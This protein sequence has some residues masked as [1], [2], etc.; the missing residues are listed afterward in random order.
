V[1]D[2]HPEYVDELF[3]QVRRHPKTLTQLLRI[4]AEHLHEEDLAKL[5]AVQLAAAPN[6]LKTTLIASLDVMQD[7]PAAMNAAAAA[8]EARPRETARMLVQRELAVKNTVRA[9]VDV[10]GENPRAADV[11]RESLAQNSDSLAAIITKDPELTGALFK[12]IAKS[13]LKR[14]AN[15]FQSFLRAYAE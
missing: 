7:K 4:T 15:E 8:I 5:T 1:L 2:E 9:L 6:G 14:G 12:S 13:G 11:F 3:A 10:M